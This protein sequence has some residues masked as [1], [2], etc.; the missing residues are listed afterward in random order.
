MVKVTTETWLV[1]STPLS[2]LN[3]RSMWNDQN[4]VTSID[5][6]KKKVLFDIFMLDWHSLN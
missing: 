2:L 6:L 5:T 3:I 1:A 4:A